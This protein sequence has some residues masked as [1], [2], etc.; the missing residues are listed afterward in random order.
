MTKLIEFIKGLWAGLMNIL[1]SL[2]NSAKEITAG[3]VTLLP[4]VLLVA[5]LYNLIFEKGKLILSTVDLVMAVLA[6]V[7]ITPQ[8]VGIGIVVVV[9][10]TVVQKKLNK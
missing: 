7:G 1:K 6:K 4:M 8:W 9:G 10:L 3:I 5:G 2:I